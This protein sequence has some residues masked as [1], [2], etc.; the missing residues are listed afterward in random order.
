MIRRACAAAVALTII[1]MVLPAA[2]DAVAFTGSVTATGGV[3]PDASCAPL[4]LRAT[5]LPANSAGSS[6]L[7]AFTYGHTLCTAGGPGPFDGTFAVLYASDMFSGTFAGVAS[8][9]GT[10]GLID[11]SFTYTVTA[12]TGRFASGTGSFTGVGTLDA[13]S[14]PPRLDLKFDGFVDL[15]AVPE[16]ANWA[17]MIAGFGAVGTTLRRRRSSFG[18][19]GS[20]AS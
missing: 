13:R 2:A 19:V 4:P 14:P 7:G 12:G 3:G 16:P 10:P 20:S 6:N 8:P 9:S 1:P 5:V 18:E 11:E 17:L 15:S